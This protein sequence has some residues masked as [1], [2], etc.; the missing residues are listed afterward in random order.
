[1]DEPS[2]EVAPLDRTTAARRAGPTLP[3]N[4]GAQVQSAVGPLPVVVLDVDP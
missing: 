2:K 4:R 1:V 3:I